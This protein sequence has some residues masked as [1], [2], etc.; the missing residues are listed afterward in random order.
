MI[1]Y[2]SPFAKIKIDNYVCGDTYFDV[3]DR[4]GAPYKSQPVV[5][6]K[7]GVP[8]L[9][10]DWHKP[11]GMVEDEIKFIII[12]RGQSIKNILRTV[13]IIALGIV[14]GPIAGLLGFAAGTIGF[15]LVSAAIVIGGTFLINAFL[16]PTVPKVKNQS[17]ESASPTYNLQAQGNAARLL[18]PI[19]RL[20]GRHQLFPDFASQPFQTFENN[21]QYLYTLLCL[22]VGYYNL[23]KINIGESEL[24]DSTSGYSSTFSNVQFEVI[25]P[26]QRITLFPSNVNTSSEV[27]GQ[28]L[29][30]PSNW[31][32]PYVANPNNQAT[33]HLQVDIVLPRGLYYANDKGGLS[34]ASVSFEVQ[35]RAIDNLGDPIGGYSTVMTENFTLATSTPQRFTRNIYLSLGRYEVRLRRTNSKQT[36]SRYGND[37]TW[38]ALRAFIPDDNIYPDVTL[39]AIKIKASNQLSNQSS[40]QINT[41]QRARIPYL[42]DGVWQ[43]PGETNNPAWIAADILRNTVY[44]AGLPD[45][46]IDLQRLSELAQIYNNRNDTFNAVFDTS[47]TLWDALTSVLNTVRTAP[48]LVAGLVT[49]VRD[50]ER[51]L[52]RTV[53]TPQSI[54]KNTFKT[55]H[56]AKGDDSADDVIVEFL[57]STTWEN[58]EVQCTLPGSTSTK[59]ARIQM[60]GITDRSQAWRE[61]MYHAA[62]NSYRRIFANV[63]TEADG[64]LLLKGDPVIVSHDLP[65]W[66]QNGLV[67]DY[68]PLDRILVLDRNI[69]LSTTS[70]NYVSLRRRDGKEFGPIEV[71]DT[72][73]S[74]EL[75][76]DGNSLEALELSQDITIDEVLSIDGEAK[77][78]AFVLGSTTEYK[79]RFIVVG[80][81]MRGIDKVDLSLVI[82]DPRVYAADAGTAPAGISYYGP[83]TVPAGPEVTSL[84]ISQDP[85]SEAD[86]VLINAIWSGATGAVSYLLQTSYDGVSWQT[87][88]NGPNLTFQFTANAGPLYV[89]VAAFN[90]IA[91]PWKNINPSPQ[92]FGEPSLSPG[93]V[94]NLDAT[95]DVGAG[96]IQATFNAAPRATSYRGE[97]AIETVSGS[98]TFNIVKL[99][100]ITSSPFLSWTSSE[101]TAAGGP[102]SRIQINVY[103]INDYGESAAVS[104]QILGL[105]LGAVTGLS[106]STPY[107]GVETNI[108]WNSV[109]SATLYRVKIYN[110]VGVLVRT[111]TVTT[112]GYFYS[113]SQLLADGGPWRTFSVKVNAEN[114]SLTGPDTTLNINDPAPA[115]PTT[116]SSTSPSAGRLDITWS[117]VSSDAIKYQVFLSTTNGFTPAVGNRVFDQNA[118]GVSI[119]GLASGTTYYYKVSTIDNYAGGTG[120][121]YSSQFSR[122]VT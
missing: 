19:P 45:S 104:D 87:V 33:D 28:E 35:V 16:G 122:L 21:D 116:I 39:L 24:W 32:G 89:R 41:I 121:L 58:S 27:A 80:S 12:P 94:S 97:V 74:N 77:D 29:D 52:A 107:T 66:S 70:I 78:T 83:G 67:V 75:K 98:G 63:S 46:R 20:Y 17:S 57:D 50:Q 115:A 68:L 8:V 102:W 60:F 108:Q 93:L 92:E 95:A 18:E 105:S 25:P 38:Q 106:L 42:I 76:L 55:T 6:V 119:T 43:T 90:T 9:R 26:G 72:G 81:S 103:A 51:A 86:P 4:L 11:I 114:A 110:N 37:I 99:S 111:T 88:Y 36:D 3:A 7:N 48:I 49:F 53:I 31:L 120:Y 40:T 73:F 13:A 2:N 101:I 65:G 118:L 44:G 5:C 23:E 10:K 82:D 15:A 71:I 62:S 85:L 22:G 91:G 56:I 96:T 79:K 113:N 64:R 1:E 84:I 54:L 30:D 69:S 61:G 14:A 59:P 117:A 47:K 100:K 34:N 112:N 109:T